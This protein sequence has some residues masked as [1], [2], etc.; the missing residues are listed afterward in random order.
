VVPHVN[1][2]TQPLLCTSAQQQWHIGI[3]QLHVFR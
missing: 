1:H 2:Q 3:L